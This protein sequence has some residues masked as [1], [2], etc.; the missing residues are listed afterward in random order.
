MYTYQA[1]ELE[2]FPTQK[3]FNDVQGQNKLTRDFGKCY[4]F[5]A[6]KQTDLTE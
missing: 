2:S 1:Q 4:S 3:V 5:T 6:T